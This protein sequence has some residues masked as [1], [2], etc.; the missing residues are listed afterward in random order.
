MLILKSF[1]CLLL[2]RNP[3]HGTWFV[4]SFCNVFKEHA[5]NKDLFE[6]LDLVKQ[7]SRPE[8]KL[9]VHSPW[10]QESKLQA[11]CRQ[12]DDEAKLRLEQVQQR[13]QEDLLCA[14]AQKTLSR[15]KRKKITELNWMTNWMIFFVLLIWII[16]RSNPFQF[17][18]LSMSL[19]FSLS[20]SPSLF[21]FL[22]H[23]FINFFKIPFF[24]IFLYNQIFIT[25]SSTN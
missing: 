23:I 10:N 25:F 7:E 22:L 6:L 9:Q 5:Y 1:N 19:S 2:S 8:S 18:T 17:P 20:L 11:R 4:Q 21:H 14:Q 15:T 16:F 24:L 3:H 13:R 12:K